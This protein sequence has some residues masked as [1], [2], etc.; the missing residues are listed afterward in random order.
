MKFGISDAW[1]NETLAAQGERCA[2]CRSPEPRGRGWAIDHDHGC[3]PD[4]ATSCGSCI[5][6]IL[7][8]PCNLALGLMG[9]SADTLNAAAHYLQRMSLVRG[10]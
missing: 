1:F 6:G 3:C 7:C 4:N 10:V 5:R 2:I 9:D 8:N